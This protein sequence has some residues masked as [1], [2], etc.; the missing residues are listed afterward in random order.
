MNNRTYS[1]I[2]II[3]LKLGLTS[4]GGPLAHIGFFYKEFVDRRRWLDEKHYLEMVALFQVLPGPTSSQ[5]A[6]S[7][8]FQRA[9]VLGALLAT[10]GFTLPSAIL[11]ILIAFGFMSYSSENLSLFIQ[12]LKTITALVVLQALMTM[13]KSFLNDRMTIGV[14]FLTTLA[15][16]TTEDSRIQLLLILAAPILG[17]FL[18]LETKT[19][20]YSKAF[21]SPVQKKISL[22]FLIAAPC[23]GLLGLLLERISDHLG[24]DVFNLFYR[25]GFLV[26]GGGHVVLPLLQAEVLEKAWMSLDTFLAGYGASQLIPGPLFSFAG[27]IGASIEGTDQPLL[28]AMIALVGIFLP[29]FLLV[30]GVLPFW[31]Q[32]RQIKYLQNSLVLMNATVLGILTATW[33]HPITSSAMNG[34]ADFCCL[35][36]GGYLL[37]RGK[38]HLLSV[39]AAIFVFYF[40]INSIF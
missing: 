23:L 1:E 35:I 33:I 22:Y 38:M 14:F 19:L 39:S 20:A 16:L 28:M 8:G 6:M 17:F 5:V 18:K 11:L 27:F 3:F 29:A 9:G 34:F 12:G 24:F 32:L 4:F 30:V 21:S 25:V 7:I 36:V 15:I 37:M 13:R 31:N 26:F 2:F 40:F 10:L